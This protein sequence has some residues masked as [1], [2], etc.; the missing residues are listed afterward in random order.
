[1][2][3]DGVPVNSQDGTQPGG[4]IAERDFRLPPASR[5]EFVANAPSASVHLAQLVTLNIL[6]GTNGDDDP[7]RPIFNI[8]LLAEDNDEPGTD[9]HVGQFTALNPNQKRFAGLAAAPIAAKR[10]VF[11]NEVQPTSFFMDVQGQPEKVFDP[12]AAP[13]ITATQGTVEEWIVENHTLENHEFHFHQLHFLVESQNNFDIN[14][15]QPAPGIVGQ[16]LDMIEVPNWDGNPA[17]P[18]PS[19]TLR[20]DFR[21]NDIGTF[22]FHCHILNHEDLGMMNIIQVV[23]ASSSNGGSSKPAAPQVQGSG[24]TKTAAPARTSKAAASS[25]QGTEKMKAN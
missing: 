3:V 11:F 9:D 15:D 10:V 19:V 7:N 2:A 4:P 1:V 22:V 5:V 21:G 18:F 23:A 16:Y 12:N 13:A 14:K 25:T 8:Q 24:A 20:I 17:H 6:T